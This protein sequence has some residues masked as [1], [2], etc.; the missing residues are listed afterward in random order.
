[1]KE[2]LTLKVDK[3]LLSV[4]QL[5]LLNTP[6][7]TTDYNQRA[8][9]W[10]VRKGLFPTVGA[11]RVSG[12]SVILEDVAF[13]VEKLGD[14]IVDL[15][16]L[17]IQFDYSNA[18]IF[19]HAKDGNIHF[20]ITQSFNTPAEV[21]RYDRF[22]KQVVDLVIKYD[23]TLKAEHGNGRNIAP[24]VEAEWGGDAYKIMKKVKK[25]HRS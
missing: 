20:L 21:N 7:F 13:P 19:G 23:G 14:A 22:L 10:R 25:M 8:F 6:V 15:Q 9:L 4:P 24:F 1:M 5:S 11:V 18:I 3:F 16:K 17:F 2:L 12:T